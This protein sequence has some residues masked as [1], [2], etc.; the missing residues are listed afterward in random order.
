M[1]C[2]SI[3]GVPPALNFRYSFVHLIGWRE[4]ILCAG[5][6]RKLD[7]YVKCFDWLSGNLIPSVLY[8]PASRRME[9]SG[10]ED[11]QQLAKY[12]VAIC[13]AKDS[14]PIALLD[15]I[16]GVHVVGEEVFQFWHTFRT[17]RLPCETD[18]SSFL[19]SLHR[20]Q[21][22]HNLKTVMKWEFSP[23]WQMH[24]ASLE[25]V[26]PRIFTGKNI[27]LQV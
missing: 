22:E 15:A 21:W 9:D 1:G 14:W 24:I 23:S 16:V 6:Y 26:H 10:N 20:W 7:W 13:K 8:L 19:I 5:V 17:L 11:M 2:L 25:S 3:A 12:E 4:G 27:L 18:L